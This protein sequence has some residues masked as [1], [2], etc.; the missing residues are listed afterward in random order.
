[1]DV[2]VEGGFFFCG[3]IVMEI[4][5]EAVAFSESMQ[6][7]T[8]QV[9]LLEVFYYSRHQSCYSDTLRHKIY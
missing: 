5:R 8:F 3:N 6:N 4:P 9:G 7:T 1:M 2:S